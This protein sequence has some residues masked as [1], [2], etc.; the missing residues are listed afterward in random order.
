MLSTLL[1]ELFRKPQEPPPTGHIYMGPTSGEQ[2]GYSGGGL[3][4]ESW[5]EEET[6]ADA[7][8]TGGRALPGEWVGR[9][10][11]SGSRC[12]EGRAAGQD[13]GEF[14]LNSNNWA[15]REGKG[16]EERKE[17]GSS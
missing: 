1:P 10:T 12:V 4:L 15:Q 14:L 3:F 5:G 8:K 16:I 11:G 17:E 7:L 6:A 2:P 9:A 13:M